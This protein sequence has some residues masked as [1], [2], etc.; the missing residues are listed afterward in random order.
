MSKELSRD[1]LQKKKQQVETIETVRLVKEFW[2]TMR[3]RFPDVP[4]DVTGMHLR[5]LHDEEFV[6]YSVD[7]ALFATLEKFKK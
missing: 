4:E 3:S 5:L 7:R 6:A 2:A 1:Q